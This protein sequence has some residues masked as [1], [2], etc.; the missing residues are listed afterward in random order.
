MTDFETQVDVAIVGAGFAGLGTAIELKRAG[1]QNF[2]IFEG[3]DGVGGSWRTNTYPGC[4]CDVPS[5][6]YSYSFEPNPN[7]PEAFSR[8]DDIRQ[9]IEH[10]AEKYDLKPN[11]RFATRVTDATFDEENGVWKITASDGSVTEARVFV[12]ATG[13]L[14]H[15][16]YPEI[17]GMSRYKGT[18]VH[19][20][21]W[22]DSVDL[23][24]KRV[25]VLG[26]GASAIQVV[27]NIAEEVADLKVFQRTASWV[28]PKHNRSY[29]RKQ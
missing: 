8:Q 26:S 15:P 2:V 17:K 23:R 16:K 6:L 10:C 13:A 29:S 28:L 25:G 4:A 22:D 1:I 3:E 12:P 14:S 5:H 20:A 27:P 24:G 18:A 7:W 21:R 9:Y 19:A 11:I